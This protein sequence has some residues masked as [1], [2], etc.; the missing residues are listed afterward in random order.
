[1]IIK[2]FTFGLSVTIISWLAGMIPTAF[3]KNTEYYRTFSLNLVKSKKLNKILGLDVFKWIVKNTF[4]KYL[5]QKLKLGAKTETSQLYELR[6]EMTFAEISHLIGFVFVMVFACIKSVKG[7][8]MHALACT[9]VNIF[10][11]LY[12]SLLQ[13][14]NKRRI[15]TLI[16]R[17]S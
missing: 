8:Y 1:M 15:D 11:N 5:N 13:Q 9:I 6:N 12:P 16:R 2:A 10:L 4:F 17:Y 7:E 14:E 3:L